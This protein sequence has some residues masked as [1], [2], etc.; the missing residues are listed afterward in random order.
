MMIV[1]TRFPADS[2]YAMKKGS[3]APIKFIASLQT[4]LKTSF[5]KRFKNL[6]NCLEHAVQ[7]D[8]YSCGILTANTIAHAI[9]DHPLCDSVYTVEERLKWFIRFASLYPAT[10]K[11]V[12]ASFD[13]NDIDMP[14]AAL[15]HTPNIPNNI[16]M[17]LAAPDDAPNI[18]SSQARK[19]L[20]IEDLLNPIDNEPYELPETTGYNSDD[21]SDPES[22]TLDIIPSSLQPK[23]NP[24]TSSTSAS[25]SIGHKRVRPD[26]VADSDMES[27]DGYESS[28]K[29]MELKRMVKYIK[30]GKG[31]SRSAKAS[32]IRREKFH[33]GTLKIDPW[34]IEAWKKKVLKDDPKAEFDPKEICSATRARHSGCGKYVKM[35]DPCDIGR[36]KDHIEA[37]NKKKSKKHAGGTPTLFQLGWAKVAVKKKKVSNGNSDD[38]DGDDFECDSEPDLEEVPCPGITASEDPRVLQYLKRTGASGGGGRSLPVI[39]KEL[40]RKLFSRLSKKKSRKAVVDTQMHE[41]KWKNDHENHRV[42]ATSCQQKVVDRSPKPPLPC[43]ECSIVFRSKAFKNAIRRP[44][45]S[46]EASKFINYRFRNP[47]LGSIYAR[48]IG[49]RE[50]VEDDVCF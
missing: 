17:P 19:A 48:T 49:V 20:A 4:W 32:R 10:S 42:Y 8:S 33:D 24:A 26:S 16:N 39:A 27:S 40:F 9:L 34:R 38:S 41:W 29:S 11:S 13:N 21:S 37:C 3:G 28:T 45:P 25:A 30:A 5:Q 44:V 6:G 31:T 50:I 2:L 35:K 36:W 47:L 22:E 15:D 18:P 43:S 23:S 1:L 46:D 12:S 7:D 14:L